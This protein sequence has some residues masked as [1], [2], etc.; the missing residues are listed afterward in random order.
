MNNFSDQDKNVEIRQLVITVKFQ[1][2][3]HKK[4]YSLPSA[5]GIFTTP[6]FASLWF[7]S[8][9][10]RVKIKVSRLGSLAN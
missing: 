7:I 10:I 6:S 5:Y 1:H 8:S 2:H 3:T 9:L 4:Y